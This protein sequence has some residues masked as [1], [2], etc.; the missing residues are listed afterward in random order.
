VLLLGL[1]VIPIMALQTSA[2]GAEG[3]A[4]GYAEDRA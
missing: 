1:L 3:R 4:E 2:A